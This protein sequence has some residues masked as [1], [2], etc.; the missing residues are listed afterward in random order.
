MLRGGP[1]VAVWF[2][3]AIQALRVN[4]GQLP[5]SLPDAGSP[6]NA[7]GEPFDNTLLILGSESARVNQRGS[8]AD[9]HVATSQQERRAA[10][11]ERI[12]ASDLVPRGEFPGP[13]AA[14]R[15]REVK[16]VDVVAQAEVE[17]ELV[18]RLP[19]VL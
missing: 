7:N 3:V 18:I 16:R 12:H 1:D 11:E 5:P 4:D 14:T 10:V 8:R 6:I 2:A 15:R 17:R 13:R 9:M 19:R